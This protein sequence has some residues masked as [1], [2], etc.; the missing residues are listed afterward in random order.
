MDAIF[1]LF[2]F[3]KKGEISHDAFLRMDA[4][5][6]LLRHYDTQA[7]QYVAFVGGGG[8]Q[9]SGAQQMLTYWSEHY[10]DL[11]T[12]SKVVVL[13]TSNST[14]GNVKEI[15]NFVQKRGLNESTLVTSRYHVIRTRKIVQRYGVAANIL[16]AEDV[17]LQVPGREEEIKRYVASPVYYWSA[18]KEKVLLLLT[19]KSVQNLIR[20]WRKLRYL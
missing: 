19:G 15:E 6:H 16:S 7:V 8:L 2:H 18:L 9:P 17:L 20:I 5:A 3:Q 14:D 12:N 1:I 10:S 4:T 13:G 11:L